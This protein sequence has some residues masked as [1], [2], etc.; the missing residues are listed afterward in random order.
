MPDTVYVDDSFQV[1]DP[2]DR[3]AINSTIRQILSKP[4]MTSGYASD[5]YRN[6]LIIDG[7]RK[8]DVHGMTT[9]DHTLLKLLWKYLPLSKDR[10]ESVGMFKQSLR[11]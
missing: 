4:N 11:Q 9:N 3:S 6:I 10:C 7:V 2:K 5:A 1:R 8:E